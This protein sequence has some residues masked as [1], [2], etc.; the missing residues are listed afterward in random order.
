MRLDPDSAGY[1]AGKLLDSYQRIVTKRTGVPFTNFV[2]DGPPLDQPIKFDTFA[3][4]YPKEPGLPSYRLL[5]N[6]EV[7]ARVV[8]RYRQQ[9]L[10]LRV[11]ARIAEMQRGLV[12]QQN[13]LSRGLLD[14]LSAALEKQL[15]AEGLPE[16]I[17]AFGRSIWLSE[18]VILLW[19]PVHFPTIFW[20]EKLK[21][22]VRKADADHPL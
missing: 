5:S 14:E 21:A 22:A 10:G 9:L 6:R 15:R 20:L 8:R 7:G 3:A 18:P 1:L 19:H 2:L 12:E 4:V 11:S 13:S 17:A 16:C